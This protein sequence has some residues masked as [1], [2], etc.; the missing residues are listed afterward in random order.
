MDNDTLVSNQ[1]DSFGSITNLPIFSYLMVINE[2][3]KFV[4]ANSFDFESDEECET[5]SFYGRD[6][7]WNSKNHINVVVEI[8]S[9]LLKS[10]FYNK[11]N[12]KSGFF[13][14]SVSPLFISLFPYHNFYFVAIYPEFKLKLDDIQKDFIRASLSRVATTYMTFQ[15]E[16]K[17]V[18]QK[19][20]QEETNLFIKSIPVILYRE[21]FNFENVR[22]C[23]ACS[24]QKNCIPKFLEK[25]LTE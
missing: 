6:N 12:I 10:H 3:G 14:F 24:E 9:K 20:K 1:I 8:I 22:T 25:K 15:T 21:A 13:D 19:L 7:L 5:F 23:D 11:D 4:F 2:D 18:S 16:N 17:Q